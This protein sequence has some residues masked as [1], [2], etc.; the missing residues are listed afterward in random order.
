MPTLTTPEQRKTLFVYLAT[1]RDAVSGVLVAGRKGKQT[2]IRY[3]SWTLHE[4]ERNY[5][6]LEKLALYLLHLSRRLCRYFEAHPIKVITDQPVKQILNKL[7]AS[8]KLAKY[9]MELRA[10]NITYIPRTAVKGQMLADFINEVPMGTRHVEGV[11]AGLVLI[12]PSGTEYTNVIRLTFSSTNNEAEY[13][14]LLAGLRIAQKMKVHVLD[15]KLG[16]KLVACQIN[17]EFV[18]SN[19]GMEKYLVKAKEQA[20]LFKKF[21]I[22]NIPRNQNQKAD[23]LSKLDSVAFNHLMKEILVEV[24]NAKSVDIQE[25]STIVEEEED[26]WITPIIKCLEEGIWPTNE[27]EVGT[28]RMKIGQYVVE[29]GVLF[30]KSY[31]SPMLGCVGSL[32]E[33]YIIREVQERACGMHVGARSVVAKIVKQ[34]YYWPTMHGDTKEVVD[35]C[36]SCQIHASVPKMPKTRLTSIMSP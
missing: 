3:V 1:S 29:D 14:A 21:S 31:L 19:E 15:V 4:A 17:G 20:A 28:L 16:L 22:K 25:V 6:P 34:G 8:R 10:Y 7:E 18:A 26:N 5:A 27:N 9:V 23:M 30:K 36:D 33:N 24:L 13:E 2:P 35:K 12:D 32:Q 11:G